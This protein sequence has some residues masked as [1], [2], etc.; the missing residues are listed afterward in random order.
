MN[1]QALIGDISLRL[2]FTKIFIVLFISDLWTTETIHTLHKALL[3]VRN[4]TAGS[5]TILM[6]QI[7][8]VNESHWPL[9]V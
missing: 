8:I 1:L 3:N 4:F 2:D 7:L 9:T 5:R 6:L